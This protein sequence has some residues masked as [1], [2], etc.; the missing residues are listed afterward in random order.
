M[1]ANRR[2]IDSRPFHQVIQR[3]GELTAQVLGER[4]VVVL[5]SSPALHRA[6]GAERAAVG[7]PSAAAHIK[8]AP[9]ISVGESSG[10][11]S[12]PTDRPVRLAQAYK[13]TDATERNAGRSASLAA[14]MAMTSATAARRACR[15]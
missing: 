4:P 9:A 15:T 12:A 6:A 1:V 2:S 13:P 10:L 3:V 5:R 14:A 11:A 7:L 8:D